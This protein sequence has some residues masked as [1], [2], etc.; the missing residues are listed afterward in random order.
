MKGWRKVL[1]AADCEYEDWDDE[2]ECPICPKHKIDY[3]ECDCP[4]PTQDDLYY[5][6]VIKVV[7]YA[8]KKQDE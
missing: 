4:G 1:Y 2:H 6:R 5:Y 7:L 3:A 8:K